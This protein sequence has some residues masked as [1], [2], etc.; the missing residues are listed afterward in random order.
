MLISRFSPPVRQCLHLRTLLTLAIET[1]CDDTCV[2]VVEKHKNNSATLHF[3]KKVT[4]DNREHRG[5]YPIKAHHGH[6][7]QLAGLVRNALEHLPL[8]RPEIAHMGNTVLVNRE[9]GN[10]MR[11][12][13]EFIS[14]T[15]GPGMRANLITGMDTAKGLAVAWQVPLIGVNHMQAHALTP[16]LVSALAITRKDYSKRESAVPSFPFLSL[17]VSGGNTLLVNSN[18]LCQHE[19]LAQSIDLAIG[20][21]LDKSARDI[22]PEN[23]LAAASDVSYARVLEEYAFPEV[24]EVEDYH[25]S[26]PD[27]KGTSSHLRK[28][29]TSESRSFFSRNW[30]ITKPLSKG[31]PKRNKDELAAAFAFCGVGSQA[32]RILE[33]NPRMEDIERRVLARET[34]R[35]AFEHLASRVITALETGKAK[36]IRTLV[37]SGGVA[38]NQYLKHILRAYM[39]GHGYEDVALFFPPPSLCT[40]NAAMIAWTGIEM[41]E[42]GHRSGLEI[43]ALAKW[44]IG[45]ILGAGGWTRVHL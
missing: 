45:N 13:P 18:G 19:I 39:D 42:A 21:M 32:K 15:R 28:T 29:H 44:P 7:E 41:W 9:N 40:D 33:L 6:Q 8:Q 25:Y 23:L 24:V 31:D 22:L 10:D 35:V 37:V 11:K 5:I 26:P 17:L 43:K 38:S 12:K 36:D 3:N 14:V 1:S 27:R 30:A 20:D 16:R 34:M 4:S 2:A